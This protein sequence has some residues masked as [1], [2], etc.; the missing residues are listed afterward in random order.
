VPLL[1]GSMTVVIEIRLPTAPCGSA[2]R[3][4]GGR[5]DKT[6]VAVT[7]LLRIRVALMLTTYPVDPDLPRSAEVGPRAGDEATD[8]GIGLAHRG[9]AGCQQ[10]LNTDPLSPLNP[11]GTGGS[12][13]SRR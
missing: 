8:Q 3:T 12:I 13:F 11:P 2:Q 10:R 6:G 1:T 5:K 4:R 9:G 7:P